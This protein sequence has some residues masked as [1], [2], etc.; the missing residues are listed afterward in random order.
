MALKQQFEPVVDA[1]GRIVGM[2][3]VSS[4]PGGFGPVTDV[5]HATPGWVSVRVP[6]DAIANGAL[7]HLVEACD[8]KSVSYRRIVVEPIQTDWGTISDRR[9]L[10]DR[11]AHLGF[12]VMVGSWAFPAFLEYGPVA[13]A[14]FELVTSLTCEVLEPD[15]DWAARFNRLL[16]ASA[17]ICQTSCHVAGRCVVRCATARFDV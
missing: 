10:L 15:R 7:A 12:P 5:A 9:A 11:I 16:C 6:V 3:D 14:Y 1:D 2:V 8:F 17:S 4:A 13:V